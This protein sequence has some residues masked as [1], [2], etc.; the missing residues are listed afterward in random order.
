M[1]WDASHSGGVVA[2]GLFDIT[3]GNQI[4]AGKLV[5]VRVKEVCD[6]MTR[7][8]QMDTSGEDTDGRV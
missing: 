3:R 5:G 2:G 1:L 4:S 7:L 8:M 6:C